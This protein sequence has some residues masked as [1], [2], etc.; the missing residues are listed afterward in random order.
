VL[1]LTD[2]GPDV[3]RYTER[4]VREATQVPL[5]GWLADWHERFGDDPPNAAL[6]YRVGG[7]IINRAI[8]LE[9]LWDPGAAGTTRLLFEVTFLEQRDEIPGSIEDVVLNVDD[10]LVL[11]ALVADVPVQISN[12][13]D[14]FLSWEIEGVA[15]G[16]GILA[17]P[18]TEARFSGLVGAMALYGTVS[19]VWPTPTS[20][21]SVS[22]A[23]ECAP[24]EGGRCSETSYDE[25]IGYWQYQAPAP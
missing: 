7:R 17:A 3:L 25:V 9:S 12:L 15:S 16:S 19:V 14:T 23:G 21:G 6:S 10:T 13:Y 1:E 24:T 4:P 8:T 18:A 2:V 5:A 11:S 20:L 22:I